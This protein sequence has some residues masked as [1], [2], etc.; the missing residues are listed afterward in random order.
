MKPMTDPMSAPAWPPT[1]LSIPDL[2]TRAKAMFSVLM[3]EVKSSATLARTR[4]LARRERTDILC[5]LVPVEKIVR[6]L[7][8]T[9][10]LIYLLMTPEGRKLLKTTPKMP[11]PSPP[12][13]VGVQ[14]HSHKV[15]IPMP[16]W[17][18]IAALQPRIDPRIV[19][20]EPQTPAPAEQSAPENL[21]RAFRVLGWN[22]PQPDDQP[23][24]E[25]PRR[26]WI[27]TFGD[28][29]FP[30]PP[31]QPSKQPPPADPEHDPSAREIARRIG[32]LER[33]LS[34]REPAIRRLAKY[35]AGLPRDV[36]TLPSGYAVDTLWWWHG[37]PEYFN[38]CNLCR[39][40]IRA[41]NKLE[42]PG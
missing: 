7:L 23:P 9:E 25:A 5:R 19:A 42:E 3:R 39:P 29:H 35:I 34:N 18:T 41:F 31:K 2:W 8:V 36:L 10:A 28:T 15:T 13:P 11:M 33:V 27:T 40:A 14:K 4:K 1:T 30:L 37:R 38:A 26:N 12:P 21:S 20:P 32:A 17:Q 16:G 22:H 24:K 6:S